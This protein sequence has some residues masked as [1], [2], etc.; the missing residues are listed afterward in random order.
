MA[1]SFSFLIQYLLSDR[2]SWERRST[3]IL[4]RLRFNLNLTNL[5]PRELFGR[6]LVRPP[7][8]SGLRRS[9]CVQ[10]PRGRQR[11]IACR[12]L[13]LIDSRARTLALCREVP[14]RFPASGSSR[15]ATA[16]LRPHRPSYGKA[17]WR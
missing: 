6:R 4:T 5:W 3:E 1:Q 14:A 16:A 2:W 8:W 9:R 12:D 13:V 17:A 11:R 7:A 10:S 15:L